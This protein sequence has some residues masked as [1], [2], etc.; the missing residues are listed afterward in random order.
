MTIDAPDELWPPR[1]DRIVALVQADI[2]LNLGSLFPADRIGERGGF[3][4]DADA[5]PE[6]DPMINA[7][8]IG[9]SWTYR[10]EHL[11]TF[12]DIPPTGLQV[13]IVGYTMLRRTAAG[14]AIR[15]Y[16]DWHHVFA[17]LGS[18]HGRALAPTV[19]PRRREALETD[20]AQS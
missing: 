15:R 19:P 10:G 13:D 2:E 5:T 12:S 20:P 17:Q 9:L 8:A 6:A 7:N 16:I 1:P 18:I 3:R 11:E 14:P 4:V